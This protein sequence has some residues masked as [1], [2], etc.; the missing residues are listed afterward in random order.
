MEK[1][2]YRTTFTVSVNRENKAS[3]FDLSSFLTRSMNRMRNPENLTFIHQYSGND[4]LDP[5]ST[6][7]A[8]NPF[9]LVRTSLSP[10]LKSKF[11]MKSHEIS[12]VVSK[13]C[14]TM[15]IKSD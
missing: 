6:M 5:R 3:I 14:C 11:N 9:L 13:V 15:V 4:A 12:K 7:S 10:I 8:R 2:I 1:P